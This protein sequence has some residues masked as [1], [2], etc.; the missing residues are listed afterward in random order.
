MSSGEYKNSFLYWCSWNISGKDKIVNFKNWSWT[1]SSCIRYVNIFALEKLK[2]RKFEL[3]VFVLNIDF[4]F[5]WFSKNKNKKE[6]E[7]E[8]EEESNTL[9]NK[10]KLTKTLKK[11]LEY[12]VRQT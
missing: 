9:K 11:L 8:E 4:M 5:S 1:A 12:T 6:E 3:I 2:T 7:E 10:A